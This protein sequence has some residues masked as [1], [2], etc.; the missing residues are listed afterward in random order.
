MPKIIENVRELLL[1][2]AKK[3][4]AER[5]Y[6]GTTIRSVASA[7][8]VGI[9]TVYN[10]FPSKEM[11]VASFMAEEWMKALDTLA[12]LPKEDHKTL[13]CG[14]Y[15][16]LGS[17]AQSNKALFSDEDAAK[18]SAIG[19]AARHR[20]LRDQIA[21]FVRPICPENDPFTAEFIAESLICWAMEEKDFDAVYGVI[22][23]LIS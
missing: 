10:Y 12:A 6:A 11:L 18:V 3:Q 23:K 4:V 8:G 9:G 5:G 1:T 21:A 14:I 2:E 15:G 17:F 22:Q 19:F 13:L 16:V 7:C 20:L